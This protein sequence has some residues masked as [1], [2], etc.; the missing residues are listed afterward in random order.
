MFLKFPGLNPFLNPQVTHWFMRCIVDCDNFEERVAV[1]MRVVEI[2]V[3]FHELNNFNGV[4]EVSSALASAAVHRL[5]LTK[6][7]R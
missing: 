7:V 6:M 5:E 4:F 1:M 3:M 2:M